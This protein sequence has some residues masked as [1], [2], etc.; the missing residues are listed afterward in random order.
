MVISTSRSISR[1]FTHDMLLVCN[2]PCCVLMLV[3]HLP[4]VIISVDWHVQ[5]FFRSEIYAQNHA[6][7]NEFFEGADKGRRPHAHTI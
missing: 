7:G 2:I 3:V 1:Q 5:P 6:N 4:T